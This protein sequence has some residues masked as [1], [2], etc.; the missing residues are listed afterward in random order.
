MINEGRRRG[1]RGTTPSIE[2]P[3]TST[4]AELGKAVLE[5]LEH[6]E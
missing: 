2:I 1:L 6:S 3:A 5:T 4:P